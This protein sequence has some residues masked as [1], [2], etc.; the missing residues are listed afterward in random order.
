MRGRAVSFFVPQ[1]N[2]TKKKQK[3]K[4]TDGNKN[5]FRVTGGFHALSSASQ[6]LKK[7]KHVTLKPI[8][9]C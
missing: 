5:W 9:R 3:K 8:R 1:K 6:T 7:N 2:T 4:N